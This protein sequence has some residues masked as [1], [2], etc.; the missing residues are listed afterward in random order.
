MVF[1]LLVFLFNFF[2]KKNSL[3][4]LGFRWLGSSERHF[5]TYA[6]EWY[7]PLLLEDSNGEGAPFEKKKC[8]FAGSC[9]SLE[10][11]ERAGIWTNRSLQ[12]GAATCDDTSEN[13]FD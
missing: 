8:G 13:V 11:H 10:Q 9:F 3:L 4:S 1:Y 6:D 5:I 7:I 12:H 2:F